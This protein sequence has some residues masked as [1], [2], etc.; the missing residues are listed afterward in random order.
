MAS[1][2]TPPCRTSEVVVSFASTETRK[3]VPRATAVAEGVGFRSAAPARSASYLHEHPAQVKDQPVQEV[4]V[5]L[6]LCH[7]QTQ[8]CVGSLQK[9]GPVIEDDLDGA[10]AARPDQIS[11]PDSHSAGGASTTPRRP[12]RDVAF[13][14]KTRPSTGT[15]L[16]SLTGRINDCPVWMRS[17]SRRR[18]IRP[19]SDHFEGS[20]RYFLQM[21]IRLSFFR[22]VSSM[23]LSSSAY[24]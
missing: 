14:E 4:H 19:I 23:V 7:I 20:A 15:P 10:L 8:G 6:P 1:T 21:L 13:D 24:A 18:L 16:R 5:A 2:S 17:K 12:D 9:G 3:S 11:L 22:T